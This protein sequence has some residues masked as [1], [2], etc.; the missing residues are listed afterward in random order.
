MGELVVMEA[1]PE[2]LPPVRTWPR[3]LGGPREPDTD[4][5]AVDPLGSEETAL[6]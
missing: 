2:D 6:P 3:T 1:E 4:V 5:L